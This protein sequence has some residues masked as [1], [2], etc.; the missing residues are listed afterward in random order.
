MTA[1]IFANIN[2]NLDNELDEEPSQNEIVR[3]A[4][5]STME[6]GQCDNSPIFKLSMED[7]QI[8]NNIEFYCFDQS[9]CRMLQQKIETG[10]NDVFN[11][12]L[13]NFMLP[14]IGDVMIN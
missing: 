9:G 7:Q 8:L 11:Q 5:S 4:S 10:S 3:A 12:Y 2:S 6:S 1:K 13:V 14:I